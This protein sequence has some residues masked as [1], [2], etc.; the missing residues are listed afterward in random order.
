MAIGSL[1]CSIS[2]V[3]AFVLPVVKY[4]YGARIRSTS[5]RLK[6]IPI[7]EFGTWYNVIDRQ[8]KSTPREYWIAWGAPQATSGVDCMYAYSSIS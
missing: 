8:T 6:N 7:R 1:V 3:F 5:H 4:M 2:A